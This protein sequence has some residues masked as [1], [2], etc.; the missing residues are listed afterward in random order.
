ML[1]IAAKLNC[2]SGARSIWFLST[3][4]MS[5][6][7]I[8]NQHLPKLDICAK[9]AHRLTGHSARVQSEVDVMAVRLSLVHLVFLEHNTFDAR[10]HSNANTEKMVN[11]QYLKS[12]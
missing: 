11:F 6:V 2:R 8:C 9:T 10:S 7:D 1:A 4:R 3:R 5:T 12:P